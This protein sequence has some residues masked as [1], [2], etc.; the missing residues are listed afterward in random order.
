VSHRSQAA[1]IDGQAPLRTVEGLEPTLFVDARHDRV[2][3]R[4]Q[5]RT[6]DVDQ[7]LGE[8]FVVRE[9][10]GFEALGLQAVG[11]SDPLYRR[12]RGT[13]LLGR[14]SR[15]PMRPVRRLLRR[16][17]A[18]DLGGNGFAVLWPVDRRGA[19]LCEC[20]PTRPK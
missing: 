5:V 18:N 7:L 4:V 15:A 8:V 3:G 17:L 14:R 11:L 10:E 13:Q 1:G 20:R 12:R 19:R 9:F 16:R 2:I 6:D